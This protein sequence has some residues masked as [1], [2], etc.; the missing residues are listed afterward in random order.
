M[1]IAVFRGLL[2]IAATQA[3]Q[4]QVAYQVTVATAVF[5]VPVGRQVYLVIAATAA[6]L[7]HQDI[8][9]TQV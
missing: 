9:A 4:G 5:Q 1:A 7:E 2:V 8:Q 6:Y 3:F